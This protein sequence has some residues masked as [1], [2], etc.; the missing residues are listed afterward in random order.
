MRFLQQYH[1]AAFALVLLAIVGFC[2]ASGN[3]PL[4]LIAGVVAALSWY[5]TEGP[6]GR[7]LPHLI[8]NILIVLAS[9]AV[10][11]DVLVNPTE[12][13]AVFGRF[14][15]WIMLIKLYERKTRREYS[16]LLAITLVLILAGAVL[17]SS[18][19]FGLILVL[20]SL[21]GLYVLVLHQLYAADE[22]AREARAH[23]APD[24][25]H[26]APPLKPSVSRRTA[27]QFRFVVA[28][29]GVLGLTLSA[30]VFMFFPRGIGTNMISQITHRQDDLIPG[31]SNEVN[32]T[33]GTRITDSQTRLFTVRITDSDG[34]NVRFRSPVHLRGLVFD[35]Y[36]PITNKWSGTRAASEDTTATLE[37]G[38]D[39]MTLFRTEGELAEIDLSREQLY[40]IDIT[41]L[42]AVGSVLYT[43]NLP[44]AISTDYDA[45]I[46]INR[47]TLEVATNDYTGGYR[48]QVVTMPS[49]ELLQ[50]LSTGTVTAPSVRHYGDTQIRTIAERVVAD[51]GLDRSSIRGRYEFDRR[52]AR[53][54]EQYLRDNFTYTTNL[55]DVQRTDDDPIVR[56]LTEFR[57]GHCE[58][59]ASAMTSLCQ[60]LQIDAR[61]VIGFV[62][63]EYHE[64]EEAYVIRESNAHAWVEVRTDDNL[65]TTFDPSPPALL[66]A[67][68][69]ADES[70]AGTVRS[71]YE[72]LES[73]WLRGIVG[74]DSGRQSRLRT[75]LNLDSLQWFN[76]AVAAVDSWLARFGRNFGPVGIFWIVLVSSALIVAIVIVIQIVRRWRRIQH[77]LH[78]ER[79]ST[80]EARRMLRQLGFYLDMLD[81]LNRGRLPKPAWQPPRAFAHDLA[82]DH[83]DVSTAV[84][85]LT[86]TFYRA[87]FGGAR[88]DDDEV[89]RANSIVARLAETLGVRVRR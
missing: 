85:E 57:K 17:S 64:L 83:P 5:I 9:I 40:T 70:F 89:T 36:D 55:S 72:M 46:A 78:L 67:M 24:A 61:L 20:Y 27:G 3:I 21:V 30:I 26:L 11:F 73:G 44:I 80:A 50:T 18:L 51:A 56:F 54:I 39:D 23:A 65:W 75:A 59:F 33:T 29:I 37:T 34:R 84:I 28:M 43:M 82:D 14:A 19:L 45:E 13:V 81:V 8:V 32:L 22:R 66:E 69:V 35:S 53:A 58:Y 88:L 6:R 4:M 10:F 31:P 42:G 41:P 74:F 2:A 86:D 71:I 16:Q 25:Y 47:N 38:P 12:P 87:R 49:G 68:H 77:A 60:S 62:A 15:V 1:L 63:W 76:D 79:L 52:A 7:A 48:V